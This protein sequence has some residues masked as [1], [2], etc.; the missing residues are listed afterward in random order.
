MSNDYFRERIPSDYFRAVKVLNE[1]G[2]GLDVM[3]TG[4]IR[5]YDTVVD[6]GFIYYDPIY[7]AW[8]EIPMR[9]FEGM[10]SV[11]EIV[12]LP[13]DHGYNCPI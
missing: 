10:T 7:N 11:K 8:V 12:I 9:N 4:A 13:K 6:G 2:S 3:V 5:F 1:N